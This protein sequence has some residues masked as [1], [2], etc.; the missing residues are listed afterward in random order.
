MGMDL[1]AGGGTIYLHVEK[2]LLVCPILLSISKGYAFLVLH[3]CEFAKSQMNLQSSKRC[4]FQPFCILPSST[5]FY[6]L[7]VFAR[8]VIL[9]PPIFTKAA[10]RTV[11]IQRFQ[12]YAHQSREHPA[13]SAWTVALFT[14]KKIRKIWIVALLFIFDKY[15]LIMD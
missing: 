1:L 6:R 15:Y 4:D 2:N 8:L 12:S 5:F 7:F 14:S 3:L 9:L 11:N 10:A 13:T